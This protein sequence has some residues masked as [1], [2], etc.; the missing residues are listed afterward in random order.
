MNLTLE[1]MKKVP[2]THRFQVAK[3]EFADEKGDGEEEN[4]QETVVGNGS[5][6][7]DA[8]QPEDATSTTFS[9]PSDTYGHNQNSYTAY[10]THLKTFGRN[11]TEAIPHV[12]HY[13]NLLSA[14]S[15]LKSRPTL[16]ELHEEKVGHIVHVCRYISKKITV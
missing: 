11:T 7:G 3:V 13:R 14:T 16:A 15:P 6:T 10:G 9:L 1:E 2:S 5:V 4:I 12:D 8:E